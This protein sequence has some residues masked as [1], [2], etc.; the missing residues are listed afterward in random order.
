MKSSY[1]QQA[2]IK[3]KLRDYEKN[4]LASGLED[5]KHSYDVGDLLRYNDTDFIAIAYNAILRRAPDLEGQRAYLAELR[6]GMPRE[7]IL[8]E[9]RFSAEGEA[10]GTVIHGLR[11]RQRLARVR[12]IPVL[13]RV[14]EYLH[15]LFR[16]PRINRQLRN[17]QAEVESR[18]LSTEFERSAEIKQLFDKQQV[19]EEELAR[20]NA[21][22]EQ[23]QSPASK[24]AD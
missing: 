24:Q 20:A 12:G 10:V 19:L 15:T 22:I 21:L 23:L 14:A 18:T 6:R 7:D 9:L 2:L 1:T 4:R 8:H 3:G 17:L 5:G 11:S 13:G 16:L